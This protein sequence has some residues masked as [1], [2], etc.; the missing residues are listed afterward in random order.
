MNINLIHFIVPCID[1]LIAKNFYKR[2]FGFS[3]SQKKDQTI[4]IKINKNL[5]F[6][7]QET[8]EYSNNHYTFEVDEELFNNIIKN[9]KKEELFFGDNINNLQNKKI[10]KTSSKNE[11]YF[12]DPNSHLFQIYSNIQINPQ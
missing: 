12:I 11:I 6:E 4:T 1:S 10:K 3:S 5:S 7:L 2:I 9:L 8:E